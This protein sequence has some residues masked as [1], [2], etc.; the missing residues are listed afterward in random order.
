MDVI[1][2]HIYNL[3]PGVDD[4]LVQKILDPSYLDGEA[5]TFSDLEGILRSADVLWIRRC[6][7]WSTH[8]VSLDAQQ[9]NTRLVTDAF[10]FS[11]WYLDQLGMSSKYGTKSYCRQTLVGG[12][13]G[14]LNTTTAL[15]WHRLMGT[16]VLSA[17][18][19]GTNK[20]R[21]YAHCAKRSGRVLCS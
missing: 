17:T 7:R 19:N 14:L 20:I 11:F 16:K 10:V 2:H 13:Y 6:S 3:G 18:F 5:S 4:H 9:P 15:L 21:A 8:L 1:T 12:N